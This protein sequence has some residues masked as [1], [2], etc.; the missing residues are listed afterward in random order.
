MKIRN[1]G[2]KYVTPKVRDMAR[3]VPPVARPCQ[4][5]ESSLAAFCF[6]DKQPICLLLT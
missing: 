6:P 1:I 2:Q 4:P 5:S 3:L